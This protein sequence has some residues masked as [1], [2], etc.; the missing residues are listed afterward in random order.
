MIDEPEADLALYPKQITYKCNKK[1][2][3]QSEKCV[4]KIKFGDD[5][6]TGFPTK[7]PIPKTDKEIPVLILCNHTHRGQM[8][9]DTKFKLS[10]ESESELIEIKLK[11]RK[12][13][14]NENYD[15]TIIELKEK[16]NIK[17]FL[18]LDD[19]VIKDI[20]N[21]E[22]NNSKYLDETIYIIQYPQGDLSISF[23]IIHKECEDKKYDF[24]HLCFTNY[25]SSGSPILKRNNKVIGIHK[26]G[27][28]KY[29]L[30]TFINFPIKE[31]IEQN[32][33]DA[34]TTDKSK[35]NENKKIN[36]DKNFIFNIKSEL[37]KDLN[38][39]DKNI[40]DEGLVTL[41]NMKFNNLNQ[42]ILA[43]NNISHI[44]PLEN[45]NKNCKLISLNLMNN[46][47]SDISV[48]ERMNLIELKEL[49]LKNNIIEDISALGK[50]KL[51]KIEIL[52]LNSNKISDINI[53]SKVKFETLKE[54][55]LSKNKI[56]DITVFQNV[57]FPNLEYL[58]LK[59]NNIKNVD[60]LSTADFSNIKGIYLNNNKISDITLLSNIKLGKSGR[61]I[62]CDNPID[63]KKKNLAISILKDSII[64][65]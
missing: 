13:Y 36:D 1:I 28:K 38:L 40:D 63:E 52:D 46:N 35:K 47:I 62:L 42:I 53:L 55:Y 26:K 4:C 17:N 29:N 49:L 8:K 5:Q 32:F 31:F 25:G 21:N 43:S 34:Q 65:K 56:S 44:K 58:S 51:P 20:K 64:F 33:R 61:I 50:T 41:C 23:G 16:D 59:E 24:Q 22:N 6:G 10:I 3:E 27:N 14:T 18:E 37:I 48:L 57:K 45:I 15:V 60:A 12:F 2:I 39:S 30:G 9:D 19:L 54:L 7:I 11:G